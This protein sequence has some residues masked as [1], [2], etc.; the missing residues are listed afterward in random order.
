VNN[1]PYTIT[2]L[3]MALDTFM[4]VLDDYQAGIY[5]DVDIFSKSIKAAKLKVANYCENNTTKGKIAPAVGIFLMKNH[6][7]TDKSEIDLKHSGSVSLSSLANEAKPD[8]N[9]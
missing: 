9:K 1:E 8:V 7:F 3:A 5:D 2:G 6:G 4:D